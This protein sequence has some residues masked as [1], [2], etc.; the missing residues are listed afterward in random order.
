MSLWDALR[1]RKTCRAFDAK[2]ISLRCLTRIMH[3]SFGAIHGGECQEMKNLNLMQASYRRSAP[4]AGSLQACE[5]YVVSLR[6]DGLDPGVYHYQSEDHELVLIDQGVD[7]QRLGGLLA[8][9]MF[10]EDLAFGVFITCRFEKLWWKYP[11]SR[12]Y[13]VALI[14]AGALLQNFLL[15]S[16][17]LGLHTWPT[18]Q[19]YDEE[20]NRHLDI[21]G[22]SESVLFFAGAGHGNGSAFCADALRAIERATKANVRVN[23]GDEVSV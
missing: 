23:R 19:F 5:A 8:G 20:I 15:S 1:A 14:D 4:S 13:R 3:W 21:D 18:G 11:Q 22:V 10:A 17:A 7:A 2:P 9:Q 6:V 16:T 12:A